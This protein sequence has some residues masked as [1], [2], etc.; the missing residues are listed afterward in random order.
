MIFKDKLSEYIELLDC[1]AKDLS[2]SSGLSVATISRYR[3]GKR[4][5]E[6]GTKNLLNLIEGIVRIAQNKQILNVTTQSVSNAFSPLVKKSTVDISKLQANINTSL[7][8]LHVS[9]SNLSRFL[10]YDASYISRIRNGQR[11]PA[12]P[13]EFA[14]GIAS[15]IAQRYQDDSYRAKVA[16]LIGCKPDQLTNYNTYQSL[17]ADWLTNHTGNEKAS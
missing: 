14:F 5:P 17:F 8:V 13:Q 7:T 16:N 4:I 1:T 2:E 10:N 12:N 11:Q 15:F 6:A 9:I 3:S